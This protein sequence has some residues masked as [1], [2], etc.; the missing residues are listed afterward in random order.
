MP[1]PPFDGGPG[2]DLER[3]W[4]STGCF[5]LAYNAVAAVF[6]PNPMPSRPAPDWLHEIKYDGYRLRLE[7][8]G[9]HVLP[10]AATTGPIATRGSSRRP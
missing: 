10:E 3:T 6:P 2:R 4:Q 7:R 5:A 9:D 1:G 8:D